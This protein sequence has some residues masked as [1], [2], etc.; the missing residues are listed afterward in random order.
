MTYT[1]QATDSLGATTTGSITVDIVDDVPTAVADSNSVTEG[2]LLSVNAAS[3]VLVNDV[4]GADGPTTVGGG[5]V[6]VRLE[7]GDATTA[8]T[9]GVNTPIVGSYGTLTLQANGSYTYQ[10]NADAIS[11]NVTDHFVYT[12]KDGDGDLS[13]ITLDIDVNNV[14]VGVSDDDALVYE[15]GLST[16]SNAVA[17]SEIFNGAIVPSEATVRT[18]TR[19]MPTATITGT[20]V[21]NLG[22]LAQPG[23]TSLDADQP[24]RHLARREQLDQHR[25][26]SRQLQLHRHGFPREHHDWHDPGRY[27]RRCSDGGGRQQQRHRRCPAQR[28]CGERCPGQ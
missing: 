26:G 24:V 17:D 6:G 14:G 1:Y 11:S 16:G 3:G 19:W 2:A 18:P 27:R 21:R 5:V 12:I 8:V 20:G 23:G 25:A 22:N 4:F 10:A 13:T 15:A 7:G 9:S 28:Q